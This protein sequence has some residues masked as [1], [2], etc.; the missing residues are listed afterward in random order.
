MSLHKLGFERIVMHHLLNNVSHHL[1]NQADIVRC[2]LELCLL[3]IQLCVAYIVFFV[4]KV[5]IIFYHPQR[6]CWKVMFYT[7]LWFCSQWESV[8]SGGLCPGGGLC[9][10]GLCQGEPPP[11][12]NVRVVCILLECILVLICYCHPQM[13]FGA[14]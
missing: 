11:Y 12:S 9:T 7:C 8:S 6:N 1:E 3:Q 13:K 2:E 5:A 14:R 10:G 4:A